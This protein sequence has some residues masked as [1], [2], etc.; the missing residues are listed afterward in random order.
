M[1]VGRVRLSVLLVVPCA[2]FGVI[3]DTLLAAEST[4]RSTT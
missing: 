3:A 4:C 1:P 2:V